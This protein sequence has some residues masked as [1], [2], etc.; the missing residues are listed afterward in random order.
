MPY[1]LK[2]VEHEEEKKKRLKEEEGQKFPHLNKPAKKYLLMTLMP[3]YTAEDRTTI[4][5][6]RQKALLIA[7]N[8]KSVKEFG[9]GKLNRPELVL[10]PEINKL[11]KVFRLS[12]SECRLISKYENAV[13]NFAYENYNS[14]LHF[15][16]EIKPE[17]ISLMI[18]K[19]LP[20]E[21]RTFRSN[22][23]LYEIG[24]FKK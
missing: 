6:A 11:N 12:Q 5:F 20:G 15:Y 16:E 22:G 23:S 1:T 3:Y 8:I 2:L 7:E 4:S 9:E 18:N 21:K 17:E 24:F 19:I 13:Q 10:T 14:E